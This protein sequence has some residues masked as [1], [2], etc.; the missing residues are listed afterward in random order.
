MFHVNLS[1]LFPLFFS[2]SN[3]NFKTFC[4]KPLCWSWWNKKNTTRNVIKI[5]CFAHP[6][7]RSSN[8]SKHTLH[9]IYTEAQQWRA[10]VA[11]YCLSN[12][13]VWSNT[14]TIPQKTSPKHQASKLALS[15][16]LVADPYCSIRLQPLLATF[17]TNDFCCYS[18]HH[19]PLFL[20]LS[21]VC[22]YIVSRQPSVAW[23]VRSPSCS[24]SPERVM[25]ENKRANKKITQKV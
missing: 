11:L 21:L 6:C 9:R 25:V 17:P 16:Q 12:T 18:A 3:Y 19:R 14:S 1:R 2:H 8:G 13:L 20:H 15:A 4:N 22:T 10:N 5:K 24:T 23:P 7:A